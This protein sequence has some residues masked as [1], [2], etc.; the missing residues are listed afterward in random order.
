MKKDPRFAVN[1]G[2]VIYSRLRIDAFD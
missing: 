1:R 2:S